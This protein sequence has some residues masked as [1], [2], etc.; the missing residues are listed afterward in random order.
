MW[1]MVTI[2]MPIAVFV[3][4]SLVVLIRYD[5]EDEMIF[6]F[7]FC[8]CNFVRKHNPTIAFSWPEQFT[9]E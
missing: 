5:T 3:L 4:F 8:G 6:V 1:K 2:L 7:I 9:K